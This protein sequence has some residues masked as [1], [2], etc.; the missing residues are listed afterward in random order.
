M[1]KTKSFVLEP[2]TNTHKIEAQSIEVLKEDDNIVTMKVEGPGIISHGE[3]GSIVTQKKYVT[4]Y[5][6]QEVNPI[7]KKIEDAND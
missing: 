2:T 7:T 3:H 4:K 1:K 5:V 6:Q